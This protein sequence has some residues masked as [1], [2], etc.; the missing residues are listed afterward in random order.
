[1]AGEMSDVASMEALN[2]LLAP[3]ACLMGARLMTARQ[4]RQRQRLQWDL[5]EEE[6]FL[7]KQ[8]MG[9]I[10]LTFIWTFEEPEVLNKKILFKREHIGLNPQDLRHVNSTEAKV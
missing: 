8:K 6:I 2:P 7:C 9:K 4:Q 3:K 5:L 10:L 1:M